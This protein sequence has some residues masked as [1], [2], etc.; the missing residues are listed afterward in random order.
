MADQNLKDA[1]ESQS[2]PQSIAPFDPE[3]IPS[4]E[5]PV[6]QTN[7]DPNTKPADEIKP[8]A[9]AAPDSTTTK[10]EEVK[11]EEKPTGELKPDDPNAKSKPEPT[12]FEKLASG[13]KAP[14]APKVELPDDIK[15]KLEE[16]D[17]ITS[18]N[19]FKLFNGQKD[20]SKIDLKDLGK[21][22]AGNNYSGL[23]DKDLV[24]QFLK[25]EYP[26][27][28]D[29]DLDKAV[30]SRMASLEKMEDWEQT[31]TRLN[32]ISHLDKNQKPDDVFSTLA[33][34]QKSQSV[35]FEEQQR[36]LIRQRTQE[37]TT[38]Y[39]D[40]AKQAVGQEY[41][42]YK[43][44]EDDTKTLLADFV[45]NIQNF[46]PEKN[47]L[48][49]LKAT[50]FE[51]AVEAAEKRGFE[52]GVISKANPDQGKSTAPVIQPLSEKDK[53]NLPQSKAEWFDMQPA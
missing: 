5:T 36:Q 52:K 26:N 9:T 53:K 31:Q 24:A 10:S 23:E 16:Y 27:L 40:L 35:N 4:G 45:E 19:L 17:K 7:P 22:L 46:S 47:F 14:E 50:A 49:L 21:R 32:M 3:T 39:E 6:V 13:T 33:D 48:R 15:A 41:L 34:I 30:T 51:K 28:S 38:L 8:T 2:I 37:L 42:G 25:L 29:V 20:L 18:S 43:L 44:T 12:F 1:F 11:P